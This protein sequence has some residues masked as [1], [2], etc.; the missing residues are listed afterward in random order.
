M[1][2]PKN[3]W[4]TAGWVHSKGG[5]VAVLT[6]ISRPGVWG[7]NF[8]LWKYETAPNKHS[9]IP[10]VFLGIRSLNSKGGEGQKL[11]FPKRGAHKYSEICHRFSGKP[12]QMLLLLFT[13]EIWWHS[14]LFFPPLWEPTNHKEEQISVLLASSHKALPDISSPSKVECLL[15]LRCLGHRKGL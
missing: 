4:E 14:F 12:A 15:T 2:Q 11:P 9:V 1:T 7:T 5:R 8:A 6:S 13:V 10:T 3:Q